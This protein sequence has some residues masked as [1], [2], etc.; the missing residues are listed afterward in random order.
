MGCAM[1]EECDYAKIGYWIAADGTLYKVDTYVGHVV[2]L[3]DQFPDLDHPETRPQKEYYNRAAEEGWIKVSISKKI[4]G[5]VWK[6]EAVPPEPAILA[7]LKLLDWLP[8]VDEYEFNQ[9]IERLNKE[10]A[11]GYV[12]SLISK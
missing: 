6:Y 2:V 10:G 8:E 3:I 12:K 11:V 1:H 7:M 4:I 9:I 5:F